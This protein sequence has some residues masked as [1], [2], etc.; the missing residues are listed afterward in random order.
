M[1]KLGRKIPLPVSTTGIALLLSVPAMV[2][3]SMAFRGRVHS[4]E[5]N[6]SLYAVMTRMNLLQSFHGDPGRAPPALWRERLGIQLSED[7]WNLQGRGLWWQGWSDDGAAYLILPSRLWPSTTSPGV[8][9]LHLGGI[10]VIGV[11]GLHRHQLLTILSGSSSEPLPKAQPLQRFCLRELTEKPAVMWTSEGL[12]SISGS[13]VSLLQGARVGC[14]SLQLNGNKMYWQGVVGSRPF[15]SAPSGL[16]A[17][18]QSKDSEELSFP[19]KDS[20]DELLLSLTSKRTDLLLGSLLSRRIIRDP[21]ETDYGLTD[22]DRLKLGLSPLE[23]ILMEQ[24]NGKFQAS[25]QMQL[26]LTGGTQRWSPA[27]DAVSARLQERGFDQSAKSDS[28]LKS[29]DQ[30]SSTATIWSRT[31]NGKTDVVGGW[32]WHPSKS[33]QKI[34][35]LKTK[36]IY[37][38]LG[39]SLGASPL[40]DASLPTPQLLADTAFRLWADPSRIGKLGMLSGSWPAVVQKATELQ[41][42]L[43][44]LKGG[45][46]GKAPWMWMKGQLTLAKPESP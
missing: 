10:V 42:E 2:L 36:A 28:T 7:L 34:K 8:A 6:D 17:E 18:P 9:S 20:P 11:D 27:V 1:L 41:V 13:L 22:K 35:N 3:A 15:S 16:R 23:L 26:N 29:R 33:G 38:R 40:A 43:S 32:I 30:V 19:R 14:L 21:L 4:L 5:T 44:E 37:N 31:E 12:A 24:N 46:G 39:L 45:N 25:I